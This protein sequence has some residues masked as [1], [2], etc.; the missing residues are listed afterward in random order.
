M[1][2]PAPPASLEE[3][4]INAA[5]HAS[6]GPFLLE[7]AAEIARLRGEVERLTKR[8]EEWGREYDAAITKHAG[9]IVERGQLIVALEAQLS[10]AQA[11]MREKCAALA[12]AVGVVG[13]QAFQTPELAIAW[14]VGVSDAQEQI[15][16]AL[17]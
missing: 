10:T 14:G 1:T 3:R 5:R 13:T 2:N 7:L 4:A 17:T 8:C 12:R 11:D 16:R 15:V 9:E 6:N